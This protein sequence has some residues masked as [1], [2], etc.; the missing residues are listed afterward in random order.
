MY[1]LWQDTVWDGTVDYPDS[2]N[3]QD[4]YN[5]MN[6]LKLAKDAGIQSP[7][8]VKEV[9]KQ[10]LRIIVDDDD[11]YQELEEEVEEIQIMSEGAITMDPEVAPLSV[12]DAQEMEHPS[13][14]N[15]EQLVSHLMEMTREGYTQAQILELHPEIKGLFNG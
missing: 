6:M 5:D 10:M 14:D 9:E 7:V 12:V 11:R 15:A 2:F 1:A 13:V 8:L 4:K 3:I